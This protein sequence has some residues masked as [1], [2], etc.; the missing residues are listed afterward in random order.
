MTRS[1][2]RVGE[3]AVLTGLALRAAQA[4]MAELKAREAD[5]RQNLT[6]L[7]AQKTRDPRPQNDPALIAGADLRWQQW[8]DQ[9][10]ATVNAELA[11]VLAQIDNRQRRLRGLFG[12]DQAARALVEKA[13]KDDRSN[14]LRSMDYES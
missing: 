4:E 6:D 7:L 14:R 2:D 3:L 9:R 5:L 11:Q 1:T 8:V 12:R 10:R 13:R